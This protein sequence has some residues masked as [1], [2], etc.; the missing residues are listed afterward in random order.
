MEGK[1]AAGIPMEGLKA[2]RGEK[3]NGCLEGQAKE[4]GSLV[5]GEEKE[6]AKLVGRATKERGSML[7]LGTLLGRPNYRKKGKTR[8]GRRNKGTV[9]EEWELSQLHHA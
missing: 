9:K 5:G 1:I 8:S 3:R 4:G 7:H 6:G 2:R